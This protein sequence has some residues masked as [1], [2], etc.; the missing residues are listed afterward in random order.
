M[1]ARLISLVG[2]LLV[3]R[4]GLRALQSVA[5]VPE[6]A[7]ERRRAPDRPAREHPAVLRRGT[8][9][10]GFCARTSRATDCAPAQNKEEIGA[11][12]GTDRTFDPG[13][14]VPELSFNV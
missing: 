14:N 3:M 8:P 9:R 2:M 13:D 4:D 6:S 12:L 11:T 7:A 10:R 1:L 5:P